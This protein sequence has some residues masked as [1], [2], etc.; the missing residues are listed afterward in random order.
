MILSL[1]GLL[2]HRNLLRAVSFAVIYCLFLVGA[3]QS[4]F[5]SLNTGSLTTALF[6][7]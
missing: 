5:V 2:G 4:N 7:H 1:S 6:S 3:G